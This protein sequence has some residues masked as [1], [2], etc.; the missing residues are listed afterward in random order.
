MSR[1]LFACLAFSTLACGQRSLSSGEGFV[2]VPGGKVWYKIAGSGSRTP[3]LIVHG[4]PGGGSC[5]VADLARRLSDERPII[6]YD[7]L[8]G[9]RSE[10]PSDPSLWKIGR[11][12][13]ELAAVRNALGLKRVHLL[14]H[15]WGGA[16]VAEYLLTAHPEGVESVTFSGPLLSTPRWI[17]DANTL[18]AQLPEEVRQTIVEN[19][20][21]GTTNSPE[22][23]K[24]TEVF[25]SRFLFHRQPAPQFPACP[26]NQTVYEQMWG[27]SEFYATGNL[28]DFDR[29]DRLSEISVPV[30]FVVGRF[31]EVTVATASDFQG[32]IAGA[33]LQVI[34]NAG[35]VSYVDEPRTYARTIR[36]FL[37]SNRRN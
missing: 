1:W 18:V 34:E 31:D 16:V 7:Q 20:R 37:R 12:V 17:A 25:Y 9:G 5:A 22:Y 19:E 4:G 30:L 27:P 10:H 8:G 24:A 3:L 29:V 28:R 32:R 15:S 21:R 11:F 26:L 33:K 36:R 6:I 23:K 2:D 35:H 14:G 13:D